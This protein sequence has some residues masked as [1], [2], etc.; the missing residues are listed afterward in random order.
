MREISIT[1]SSD[2]KLTSAEH[3]ASDEV[4]GKLKAPTVQDKS[5]SEDTAS[6][7]QAPSEPASVEERLQVPRTTTP[8]LDHSDEPGLSVHD[9]DL[10]FR[11]FRR[12]LIDMPDTTLQARWDRLAAYRDAMAAEMRLRGL[13]VPGE[14]GPATSMKVTGHSAEMDLITL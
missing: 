12:L 9:P 10:A 1:I 3:D 14:I 2:Y 8:S 4:S 5:A 7:L 13:P 11:N 6:S